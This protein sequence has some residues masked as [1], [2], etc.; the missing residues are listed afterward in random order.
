MVR[1][2]VLSGTHRHVDGQYYTKG[3]ELEVSQDVYDAFGFKFER[4]PDKEAEREPL[5]ETVPDFTEEDE[6]GWDDAYATGAA[7]ELAEEHG[8]SPSEVQGTGLDGRVLLG[9][10]RRAL[11]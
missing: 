6:S 10:V 11:G 5:T 1:V 2:K 4:L 3:E 8:L 7:V 9:D